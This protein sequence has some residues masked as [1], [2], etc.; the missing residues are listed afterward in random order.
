M[1]YPVKDLALLSIVEPKAVRLRVGVV[2]NHGG[3]LARAITLLQDHTVAD[4]RALASAH[5]LH[6]PC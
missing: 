1:R 6:L 5:E 3:G 2:L 4:M